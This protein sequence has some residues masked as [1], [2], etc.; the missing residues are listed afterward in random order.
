MI[1]K[2][3]RFDELTDDIKWSDGDFRNQEGKQEEKPMLKESDTVRLKNMELK[4]PVINA[5]RG[6]QWTVKTQIKG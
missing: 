3:V 4:S 5:D 6:A 1:F 2:A